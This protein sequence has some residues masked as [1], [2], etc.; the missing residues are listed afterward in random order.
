MKGC[1]SE[2]FRKNTKSRVLHYGGLPSVITLQLLRL[3][4][5]K[6]ETMAPKRCFLLQNTAGNKSLGSVDHQSLQ[7]PTDHIWEAPDWVGRRHEK[8]SLASISKRKVLN[9]GLELF[10]YQ[11]SLEAATPRIE[12]FLEKAPSNGFA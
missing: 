5:T 3:P 9:N 10:E 1:H 7:S 8:H 11:I 4:Q 12:F 2:E 6:A